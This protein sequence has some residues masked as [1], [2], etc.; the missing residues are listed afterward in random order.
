MVM[1][2]KFTPYVRS[3]THIIHIELALRKRMLDGI[4]I[5]M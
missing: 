1:I 4:R 5:T 3:E 2:Q